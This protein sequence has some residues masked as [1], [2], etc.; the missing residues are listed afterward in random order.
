MTF[1]VRRNLG[2]NYYKSLRWLIYLSMAT[3]IIDAVFGIDVFLN[4]SARLSPLYRLAFLFKILLVVLSICFFSKIPKNLGLIIISLIF[5]VKLCLGIY[6]GSALKSLIGH[7]QFYLFIIFGYVSGW[8]LVRAEI[9]RITI[10]KNFFRIV[11]GLVFILCVCYFAAYQ[12][13]L[14]AY[15]GLGLQTFILVS[16]FIALRTSKLYG[17]MV[18]SSIL[19]TG[20]RASLLVFLGQIFGPKMLSRKFSLVGLF[21]GTILLTVLLYLSYQIGLAERFSA[22][23]NL[24]R[25]FDQG[26]LEKNL[27]LLYLA[28]SG[29][30]EE[31]YAFFVVQ[32]HSP[33][34]LLM[35]QVAGHEY[36]FTS[37]SGETYT[38]YYLH[39]SPL[40]FIFHFGYPLGILIFL[41][42][43][44]VFI[45]TLGYVTKENDV[46]CL[47]FIGYYLSSFFGAIILLDIFF[48]VLFF[49][50]YFLR[51]SVKK[52]IGVAF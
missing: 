20:K 17:V 1:S 32:D 25:E 38:R 14:I 9:S 10:S 34:A 44:R 45:W 21:S 29:R 52:R 24:F 13:G 50:C 33:F 49:Y 11:V 18:F 16:V 41:I 27:E 4:D 15:F 8:Q 46:F 37:I 47:L 7:I 2:S 40:N 39:V 12:V 28:T 23:L 5:L 30:T 51:K 22:I 48:W 19:L 26:D 43:L 31:I 35:G 6:F 42:Q 36:A 3:I